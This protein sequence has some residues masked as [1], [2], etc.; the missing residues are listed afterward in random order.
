MTIRNTIIMLAAIIALAVSPGSRAWAGLAV[1]P[2]Y[3]VLELDKGRPAGTFLV[4]NTST[5]EERF[6]INAVH[7]NISERGAYTIKKPEQDQLGAWIRF[8]PKE[9]VLPPQSERKVR[10]VVA[11]RG[12][13]QPGEYHAAMELESLRVNT[14]TTKSQG[15]TFSLNTLTSILVPIFAQSGEV[16]YSAEPKGVQAVLI[17]G[18]AFIQGGI[19]NTGTAN[20][21]IE[22]RYVIRDMS[23]NVVNEGFL[24][25][26]HVLP[27]NLRIFSTNIPE[28]LAG[29]KYEFQV[30]FISDK[31]DSSLTEVAEVDWDK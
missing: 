9:L 12:K 15:R 19:M 25:R 17:N 5:T 2:A 21:I 16:I 26:N 30:D 27:G 22:A 31:L 29:G 3:V 20:L 4:R 28:E 18:R 6:R 1:T 14:S 10:F 13:V 24:G 23:G 8:N 7:F 11:P